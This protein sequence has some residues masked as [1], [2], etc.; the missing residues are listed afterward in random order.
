[1]GLRVQSELH[2]VDE[3]SG[4]GQGVANHQLHILCWVDDDLSR[5]DDCFL[6]PSS[7]R[8]TTGAPRS[9]RMWMKGSEGMKSIRAAAGR[10]LRSAVLATAIMVGSAGLVAVGTSSAMADA[11]GTSWYCD[12]FSDTPYLTGGTPNRVRGAGYAWDCTGYSYKEYVQ[13]HRSEGFWHPLVAQ[14]TY[15]PAGLIDYPTLYPTNC[16]PGGSHVYFTQIFMQANGSNGGALP[17]GDSGSLN[18]CDS[19]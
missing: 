2:N 16:D 12:V 6:R 4:F 7:S 18:P 1:L 17:S 5:P 19:Q 14:K 11:T 8:S 9:V 10:R 13:L 15:G 3:T